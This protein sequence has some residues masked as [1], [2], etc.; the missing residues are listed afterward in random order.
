MN[1]LKAAIA[2]LQVEME[3]LKALVLNRPPEK[4]DRPPV[5]GPAIIALIGAVGIVIAS[6]PWQ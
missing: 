6:K 5:L 1:D 2:R 4:T 3:W